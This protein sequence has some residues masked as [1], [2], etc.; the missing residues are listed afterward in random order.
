MGDKHSITVSDSAPLVSIP[1]DDLAGN[2]RWCELAVKVVQRRTV[3][4]SGWPVQWAS[5][6][7]AVQ[8]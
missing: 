2:L 4:R 8:S 1:E 3:E 6:W 5:S 7:K